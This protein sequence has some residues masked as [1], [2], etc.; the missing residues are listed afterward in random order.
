MKNDDIGHVL[1]RVRDKIKRLKE[2]E[3][4]L[5]GIEGIFNDNNVEAIVG[6]VSSHL[7]VSKDLIFGKSKEYKVA[8]AR[9][10]AMVF[11][12]N[13]GTYTTTAVA[14]IFNRKHHASVLWSIRAVNDRISTSK[15]DMETYVK[16]KNALNSAKED[17]Q[18]HDNIDSP[19]F[20]NMMDEQGRVLDE[21]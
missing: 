7:N 5:I 3:A 1:A 2:A 16:I 17:L 12:Y 19:D 20:D 15:K 14:E 4:S 9:H 21:L 18:D 10:L 6:I 11:T 13:T 8:W